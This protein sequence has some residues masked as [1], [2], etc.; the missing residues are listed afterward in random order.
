M[1]TLEGRTPLAEL[2]YSGQGTES[3]AFRVEETMELLL[4][5]VN[6]YETFKDKTLLHLAIEN[7]HASARVLRAFLRASRM[8]LQ[9]DRDEQYLYFD[10]Q[11]RLYYSP[12]MYVHH[13]CANKSRNE[14]Q[15]LL[16][17]LES[18]HF[19]AR[20]FAPVGE[21]QPPEAT[22]FSKEVEEYSEE[23]RKR[24]EEQKRRDA[25]HKAEMARLEK[26]R[27]KEMEMI[28]QKA[29]V[30]AKALARRQNDELAHLQRLADLDRQ[31][32]QQDHTLMIEFAQ[33]LQNRQRLFREEEERK[34]LRHEN[35]INAQTLKAKKEVMALED[36][37]IRER[38][39][40]DELH[41]KRLMDGAAASRRLQ[42]T[43][44][45]TYPGMD[46]RT[47][48]WQSDEEVD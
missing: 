15:K 48:A 40:E 42:I 25:E 43:N 22:G 8:H 37:R 5:S 39:Q 9:P 24:E 32:K 13:L 26:I 44:G 30:E 35:K 12:G 47:T 18:A 6:E 4:P 36:R 34:A 31:Y 19:K 2:C 23:E 11:T 41:M 45:E 38:R 46:A 17:I 10:K 7:T 27:K 28:Q 20:Y 3:W 1:D 16:D 14:K 33:D 29:D 21:K